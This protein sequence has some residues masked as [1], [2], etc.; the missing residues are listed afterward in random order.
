MEQFVYDELISSTACTEQSLWTA[1]TA[2]ALTTLSICSQIKLAVVC[3]NLE[4]VDGQV[5]HTSSTDLKFS[6]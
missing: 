4:I 2:V 6:L 3:A 1:F 5:L